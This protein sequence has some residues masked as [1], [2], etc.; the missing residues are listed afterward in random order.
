MVSDVT[1]YNAFQSIYFNFAHSLFLALFM[2]L[3]S[4]AEYPTKSRPNTNLMSKQN[5]LVY[6]S[7]VILPTIGFI[8]AYFYFK[9]SD[10]FKSNKN[11]IVTL[12]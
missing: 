9:Q 3:S 10:G 2:A 7:N 6:W 8:G 11:P 1:N 4:A 5:H 12:E